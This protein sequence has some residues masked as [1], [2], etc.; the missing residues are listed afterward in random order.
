MKHKQ[1]QSVYIIQA[2]HAL[3]CVYLLQSEQNLFCLCFTIPKSK[4]EPRL[5]A[6][7]CAEN[8]RYFCTTQFSA[9]SS[10][11]PI[12]VLLLTPLV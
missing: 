8:I 1:S 9:S 3:I 12:V 7:R 10:F 5:L 11:S 4:V 6:K 2:S